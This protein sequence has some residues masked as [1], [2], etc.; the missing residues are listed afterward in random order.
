[1]TSKNLFFKA[2]K[3]DMRHKLWM[4][5]L[6][7]LGNFL[8][9]PVGYMVWRSEVLKNCGDVERILTQGGNYLQHI[10]EDIIGFWAGY[11]IAGGGL[12]AIVLA[13]ITGLGGFRYVFHR[14]MADTYHSLPIRRNMLYAVGYINGILIW[15][16]PFIINLLVMFFMAWRLLGQLGGGGRIWE[17]AAE[18]F[19]DILVLLVIYLLVYH[20]VLL[21]VMLSGNVLNTMFSILLLGF[22]AIGLYGLFIAYFDAYLGTYSSQAVDISL[23]AYISPLSAVPYLLVMKFDGVRGWYLWRGILFCVVQVILFGVASRRLYRRRASEVAEQGIWN[24]RTASVF[25][26]LTGTAAGM[27]GW[28]FFVLLLSDSRA[29]GWGI[30]GAVLGAAGVFG[31]LDIMFEM[32]FKAFFAHKKQMAGTVGAALLICF[33][34]LGDWFG[35][36]TYLPASDKIAAISVYDACFSNRFYFGSYPMEEM[37]YQDQE[38]LYAFLTRM[39]EHERVDDR[40][41]EH[42]RVAVKVTLNSGR[43]YDRNYWIWE[44]DQ[45]LVWPIFTSGEYME[46]AYLIDEERIS[47]QN[48]FRLNLGTGW[49]LLQDEQTVAAIVRAYN[50]D[51]LENPD[52]VLLRQGRLEAVAELAVSYEEKGDRRGQDIT[53]E[54]FDFMVHTREVLREAGFRSLELADLEVEAIV[55]PFDHGGNLTAEERVAL[56]RDVYGIPEPSGGKGSG[57]DMPKDSGDVGNTRDRLTDQN[58]QK[59][60]EEGENAEELPGTVQPGAVLDTKADDGKHALYITDPAEMEEVFRLLHFEMPMSPRGIWGNEYARVVLIKSDGYRQEWFIPMGTLPE[61]YIVRFGE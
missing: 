28:A 59:E 14:N 31:V 11:V 47:N 36:D 7:V 25:R 34:F 18:M 46:Y 16:I 44:E 38:S 32:D 53:M 12:V 42:E 26:I 17:L 50:R 43:S 21:S 8:A 37:H 23:A 20:V 9:L 40:N 6:S 24:K 39:T 27:A 4:A 57:Q 58:T 35:Y 61:K 15:I 56:A 51:V 29:A 54:I 30:F 19:L 48:E 3:E 2:M 33:A 10:L 22:G 41:G 13:V 49:H 52:A 1:M 45:E 55:L 60:N 5:A